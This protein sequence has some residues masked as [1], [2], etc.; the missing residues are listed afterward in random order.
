LTLAIHPAFGF[1]NFWFFVEN[2]PR[3]SVTECAERLWAIVEK[4]GSRKRQRWPIPQPII[5][6]MTLE[7]A[8]AYPMVEQP[9]TP[10]MLLL[11]AWAMDVPSTFLKNPKEFYSGRDGRGRRA[12]NPRCKEMVR[13][14][15]GLCLEQY[16]TKPKL[17]T[18]AKRVQEHLGLKRP[19]SR[20][21]IRTW[22]KEA[23]YDEKARDFY[24]GNA[25]D[26][27]DANLIKLWR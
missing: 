17:N 20:A 23:R 24:R 1:A 22:R 25:D 14:W 13:L 5:R 26:A 7:L 9:M 15:D 12:V 6:A 4:C 3:G 8:A 2:A 18:L 10:S 21:N 19:L 16:G 11:L 27:S